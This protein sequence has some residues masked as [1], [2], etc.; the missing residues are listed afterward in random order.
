[1]PQMIYD[2]TTRQ[3]RRLPNAMMVRKQ[4]IAN[5]AELKLTDFE[6]IDSPTKEP[7]DK[8]LES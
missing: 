8:K 7:E 4:V 2:M 5:Y 3:Q 1:M 6:D